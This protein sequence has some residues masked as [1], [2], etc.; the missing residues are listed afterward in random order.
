MDIDECESDPCVNGATC[1]QTDGPG[2]KCLCAEGWQGQHCEL[3]MVMC[4]VYICTSRSSVILMST[5]IAAG[6]NLLRG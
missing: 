3:S 5:K 2:Y 4:I 6:Y 1:E